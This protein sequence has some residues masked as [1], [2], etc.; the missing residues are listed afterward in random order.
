LRRLV[1]A[2]FSQEDPQLAHSKSALKRWRQ[3]ER[4]RERNKG[5]RSGTRTAVKKA[6]TGIAANSDDAQAAVTE[7][8]S[9]LDR[10]AK[11]N[12]IHKNAASRQKS[13][14]MKHLN[15]VTS[16]EAAA[17]ATKKRAAA[18]KTATK[19][20]KAPAKRATKKTTKK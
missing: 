15:A 4:H 2:Q 13:R 5:V 7:A 16:G 3:N 18:K 11:R 8:I 6:R 1:A 20:A 10:A 12:V 19:S 9:V 17:P 14:L